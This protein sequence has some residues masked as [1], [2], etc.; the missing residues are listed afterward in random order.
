MPVTSAISGYGTLISWNGTNIGE[1]K[2]LSHSGVKVSMVDVSNFASPDRVNEFIAGLID[3]GDLTVDCNFLTGDAAQVAAVADMLA[4]TKRAVVVTG[5]TAAAFTLTYSSA[6]VSGFTPGFNLTGELSASFVIKASSKPT[7]A[8]TA[9]NNATVFTLTTATLYP[10]FAAGTYS[11]EGTT[12]GTTFTVTATFAA[13]TAVAVCTTSTGSVSQA[14]LT[15]TVASAALTLGSINTVT[16][17]VVTITET[18]KV[19][20]VYTV[21]IAKTA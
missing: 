11:Y 18:G 7:L 12:T 10:A 3:G 2:A 5:P 16:T 1:V 21:R 13:G 9:S 6:L 14:T 17:L 4:G 20:T 15:S 8:I 19:P